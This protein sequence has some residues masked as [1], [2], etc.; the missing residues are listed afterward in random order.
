MRTGEADRD[1]FLVCHDYGMGALWWWV[2]AG[3]T[4]EIVRRVAEVEV[5]TDSEIIRQVEGWD[6]QPQEIVLDEAGADGPLAP[7]MAR[8]AEMSV[9]PGFGQL[10][11]RDKVWLRLPPS[12]GDVFFM[13]LGADGRRTRQVILKTS[14]QRW[15]S[16]VHDWPF[17]APFDLWD[18]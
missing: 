16:S 18:P 9:R 1:H 8:R 11:G 7:L 12:D 13:E 3:S 14:G 6:E 5:V 2:V 15:R 4:E 17:N 10:A